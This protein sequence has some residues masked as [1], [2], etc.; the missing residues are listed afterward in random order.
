[1]TAGSN[2]IGT[3][4]IAYV[5][6]TANHVQTRLG[7]PAAN[8]GSTTAAGSRRMSGQSNVEDNTVADTANATAPT[9]NNTPVTRRRRVPA[10]VIV[11]PLNAVQYLDVV[12]RLYAV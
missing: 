2:S 11:T 10:N 7:P 3:A 1:M 5:H 4:R 6:P 9:T 12:Q 8:A